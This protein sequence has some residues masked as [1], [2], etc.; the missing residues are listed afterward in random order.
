M[1]Y[2]RFGESD[3]YLFHDGED[4]VCMSCHIMPP[5]GGGF[6]KDF[7]CATPE[8]AITHLREH[9]AAGD[10]CDYGEVIAALQDECNGEEG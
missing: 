10:S 2:S 8:E 6:H 3:I 1:A 7:R 5:T 9:E 4:Y